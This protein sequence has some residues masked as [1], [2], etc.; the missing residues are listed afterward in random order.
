[1]SEILLAALWIGL[2]SASTTIMIRYAPY[3]SR[4]VLEGKKPLA[5][6]VCMSLWTTLFFTLIAWRAGHVT[7]MSWLPAYA[8]CKFALGRLMD[9]VHFPSFPD[10][11]AEPAE[12]EPAKPAKPELTAALPLDS[13]LFKV[14]SPVAVADS[15]AAGD[16][17]EEDET[18]AVVHQ[19][20]Q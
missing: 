17:G 1:V 9:P 10:E 19:G 18:I 3:A 11:L 13:A 5:C 20:T 2:T 8:V 16:D 15:D 4:L 6:D 12:P 7:W 14:G